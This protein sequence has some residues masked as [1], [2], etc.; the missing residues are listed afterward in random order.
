MTLKLSGK[1]SRL[2][3][4][5]HGVVEIERGVEEHDAA[6]EVGIGARRHEGDRRSQAR[7]HEKEVVLV[8]VGL[9]RE[10]PGHRLK[11]MLLGEEGHTS[12]L[13]A[14]AAVLSRA[15]EIEH[16]GHHAIRCG[17][18]R[19]GLHVTTVGGKPVRE[20]G[21]R[22]RASVL[23]ALRQ[24]ELAVDVLVLP[25]SPPLL[26]PIVTHAG[27]RFASSSIVGV[28]YIRGTCTG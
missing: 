1:S 4:A 16:V 23:K 28:K 14:R 15:T 21:R 24:E 2:G 18:A 10:L 25:L 12:R 22:A 20:D 13:L 6:H 27:L 3:Q 11:V 26:L 19:I 5:V 17:G 8:H 9:A 7:P